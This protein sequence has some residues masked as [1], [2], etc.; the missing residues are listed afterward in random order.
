MKPC[1]E[2]IAFLEGRWLCENWMVDDHEKHVATYEE[3]MRIHD[4]DTVEITAHNVKDGQNITKKMLL[5]VEGDRV[6]MKQGDFEAN[7]NFIGNK[8]TLENN[9]YEGA[10]YHFVLYLMN[11]YFV[12]E[13]EKLK[14]SQVVEKQLSTLKRLK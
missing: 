14:G 6:K 9:D 11:D 4:R 10:R 2:I 13:K 3:T 8:I 5:K 7:G 12:F 1:N